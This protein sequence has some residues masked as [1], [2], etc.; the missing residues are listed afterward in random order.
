MKH[1][2]YDLEEEKNKNIERWMQPPRVRESGNMSLVNY[3]TKM[4]LPVM[5]SWLHLISSLLGKSMSSMIDVY[6]KAC[7]Q[8]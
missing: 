8:N 4:L 7:V 5:S 3:A 1:S 2:I 6:M